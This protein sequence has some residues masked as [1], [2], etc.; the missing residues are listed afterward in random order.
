M[1]IFKPAFENTTEILADVNIHFDNRREN[2]LTLDSTWLI[3]AFK[4]KVKLIQLYYYWS[5]G[6]RLAWIQNAKGD[7]AYYYKKP[8]IEWPEHKVYM[9]F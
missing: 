6:T 4:E 2:K 3:R 1:T 7:G 9:F 8:K 5:L